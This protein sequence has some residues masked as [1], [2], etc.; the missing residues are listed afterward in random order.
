MDR[1]P[2]RNFFENLS[3]RM[4]S[5]AKALLDPPVIVSPR[6]KKV[7]SQVEGLEED[8]KVALNRTSHL[9]SALQP[10]PEPNTPLRTAAEAFGLN[11]DGETSKR[12]RELE[13]V[14]ATSPREGV[15]GTAVDAMV[16][17]LTEASDR[18]INK[19]DTVFS[20]LVSA[21]EST[22][23]EVASKAAGVEVSI[24]EMLN[25]SMP[26]IF[27]S[28]LPEMLNIWKTSPTPDIISTW[29]VRAKSILRPAMTMSAGPPEETSGIGEK[30]SENSENS[31]NPENSEISENP[32]EE[33]QTSS[34]QRSKEN[35]E[36]IL[37]YKGFG[38]DEPQE[39]ATV[40]D[41]DNRPH[42]RRRSDKEI[43]DNVEEF[44]HKLERIVT[45]ESDEPQDE[46]YGTSDEPQGEK[47]V[48]GRSYEPQEKT[49]EAT[50]EEGRPKPHL[51][52]RSDKEIGDNVE[53]FRKELEKII[54]KNRSPNEDAPSLEVNAQEDVLEDG[55]KVEVNAK[56]H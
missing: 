2:R 47:M 29:R 44:R 12:R 37:G 6:G 14:S 54:A 24:H 3:D 7:A 20:D 17:K 18:T 22:M 9:E 43:G 45:R 19:A 8:A 1:S 32:D 5:I 46:T 35:L 30:P 55:P 4:N 26:E 38:S 49:P 21:S 36:E 39:E 27:S 25:N 41:E 51:K 16:S 48:A 13:S 52:P 40:P 50:Y 53:E 15:W 11:S 31:E 33:P 34:L 23:K 42:L 28:S 10:E 56:G